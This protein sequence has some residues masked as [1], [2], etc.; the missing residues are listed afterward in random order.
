MGDLSRHVF[1][2]SFADRLAFLESVACLRVWIT[3][4]LRHG[5]RV[6]GVRYLDRY[7]INGFQTTSSSSL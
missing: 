5:G 1:A 6:V 7:I 2:L 3:G 4:E